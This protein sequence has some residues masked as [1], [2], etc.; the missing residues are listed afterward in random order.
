[1]IVVESELR[2]PAGAVRDK[3]TGNIKEG[4]GFGGD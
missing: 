2:I 4:D 3:E 1:V